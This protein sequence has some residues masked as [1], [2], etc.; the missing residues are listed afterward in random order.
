MKQNPH[1]EICTCDNNLNCASDFQTWQKKKKKK[2]ESRDD[3]TEQ[4]DDATEQL[5]DATE[6]LDD[7]IRLSTAC[8]GNSLLS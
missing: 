3:A 8:L 6:H 2:T 1:R 7:A 5:D 4:L